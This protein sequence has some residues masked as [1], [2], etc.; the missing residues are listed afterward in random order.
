MTNLFKAKDDQR[1]EMKKIHCFEENL[2]ER[3]Y[4]HC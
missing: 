4:S 1:I 3:F 2:D